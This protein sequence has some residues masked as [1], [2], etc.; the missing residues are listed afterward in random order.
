MPIARVLGTSG[1]IPAPSGSAPVLETPLGRST[2]IR[3]DYIYPK[4][5]KMSS[6]SCARV[7]GCAKRA[8]HKAGLHGDGQDAGDRRGGV[9]LDHQLPVCS[10]GQRVERAAR[11][12]AGAQDRGLL[13]EQERRLLVDLLPGL[14]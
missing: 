9:A 1:L 14:D 4:P 8:V 3:I 12:V 11:K 13:Q 5:R 2:A 10:D 6:R 7:A